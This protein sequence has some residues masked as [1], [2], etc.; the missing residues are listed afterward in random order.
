MA[1][2][3]C[4]KC[5]SENSGNFCS[6]CGERRPG[7]N[8]D[9]PSGS[10]ALLGDSLRRQNRS[11]LDNIKRELSV[12]LKDSAS[13]MSRPSTEL[14]DLSKMKIDMPDLSMGTGRRTESRSTASG[15]RA[16]QPEVSPLQK[17]T[18]RDLK[19][20]IKAHPRLN[21]A[22]VH[23]GL[24][25]IESLQIQN[26]SSET[27]ND[28]LV[29]AWLATDYGEPWQKTI[30][31]IPPNGVHQ[32]AKIVVPR[33]N[34]GFRRSVKQKEPTSGSTCLRKAISSFPK[35]IPSKSLPTTNGTITNPYERFSPVSF[36]PIPR[37]LRRS[38]LRSGT[39]CGGSSRI[40]ILAGTREE[41]EKKL[42][43]CWKPF[44][45]RCNRI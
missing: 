29:K 44:I 30:P 14:P 39:G 40:R 33:E 34:P 10:T 5:Q 4:A 22:L 11:I 35:R 2:W 1:T 25:L 8:E 43:R 41:A 16:P 28:V 20:E 19:V 31:S 13:S 26:T 36:S 6:T 42:C 27:A 12:S 32:E 9:Q 38:F 45:K 7:A 15:Q 37:P 17:V 24:P 3:R 21:Y 23:C 18:T